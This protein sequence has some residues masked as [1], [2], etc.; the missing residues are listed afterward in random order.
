MKKFQNLINR[1]FG[2]WSV[3]KQG[4]D[5]Y[6]SN[7]KNKSKVK[8]R[9]WICMCK[10]GNCNNV[11]KQISEKN[12][13]SEGS[14]GCGLSHKLN[15]LY[16]K[17]YNT[18]DLSGKHGIGYTSKGEEFYFDLEDYDKIKD[19][20]WSY[21]SDKV[22]NYIR[23]YSHTENGINKFIFLHNLVMNNNSEEIVVDHI[24]GNTINT[25]K[26]NLRETIPINNAKNLKKYSNN[27]SGCKGVCYSKQNDKWSSYIQVDNTRIHLGYFDNL[28]D[29]IKV[30]K[31]AELKYFKEYNREDCYL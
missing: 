11:I 21:H 14:K 5:V 27:K 16:N 4:E 10:C 22:N 19:Y 1:N 13:L 25:I 8:I 17:K 28:S 2:T 15:T 7:G 31:S 3:I 29:A 26:S 24:D 18:Y 30:R 23:A 12:L 6:Y 9:T 20:C